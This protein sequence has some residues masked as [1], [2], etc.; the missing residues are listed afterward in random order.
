MQQLTSR[1]IVVG[2]TGCTEVGGDKAAWV[3]DMFASLADH[4]EIRGVTWFDF[5]KETNWRIDSSPGSLDAF[6]T[7]VSTLG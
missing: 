7:G 2:E 4:P 5:D 6:R 3:T 1:P